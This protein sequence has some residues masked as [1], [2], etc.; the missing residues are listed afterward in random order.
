[1]PAGLVTDHWQLTDTSTRQTNRRLLDPQGR[2]VDIAKMEW[3]VAVSLL[4]ASAGPADHR[5]ETT[6][7]FGPGHSR[8]TRRVPRCPRGRL[9][10]RRQR[11]TPMCR[12][13]SSHLPHLRRYP[14]KAAHARIERSGRSPRRRRWRA[15]HRSSRHRLQLHD[16]D[17][18]PLDRG[19]PLQIQKNKIGTLKWPR[20]PFQ[21]CD[22]PSRTPTRGLPQANR[23]RSVSPPST[24][25]LAAAW[26]GAACTTSTRQPSR[27]TPPRPGLQRR[28]RYGRRRQSRS[29]G[30]GRTSWIRRRDGSMPQ[31][32]LNSGSIL[33]AS[34]WSG[35]AI[36]KACYGPGNKRSAA[37]NSVRY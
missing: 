28:W 10:S 7:P 16:Q 2:L 21:R 14:K 26:R 35:R 1:M 27:I 13:T 37:R 36:S 32:L 34:F 11:S 24:R 22:K 23:S 19:R 3:S 31:A 25:C 4:S 20:P 33:P 8:R 18:M 15:G 17:V 30:C 29:S 5:L 12:R 6:R 9:L